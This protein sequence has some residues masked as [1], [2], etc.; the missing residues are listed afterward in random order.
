MPG[1]SSLQSSLPLELYRKHE[2]EISLHMSHFFAGYLKDIYRLLHG[3]LAMVI[4][5]AEIAHHNLDAH[6][7]QGRSTSPGSIDQLAGT[8]EF[9]RSLN[10]CNA[11]SPAGSTGLPRETVRRKIL[12]MEKLGWLERCGRRDVRIT[13]KLAEHFFPDFNLNLVRGLLET[14]QRISAILASPPPR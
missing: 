9:K 1:K 7:N 6:F 3:D 5:L 14:A 11:H 8:A 4:V 13:P 10:P 12:H 2:G